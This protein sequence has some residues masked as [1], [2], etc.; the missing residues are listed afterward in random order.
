MCQA[1]C[2]PASYNRVLT[3]AAAV[4]SMSPSSRPE[5]LVFEDPTG[6][7]LPLQVAHF[8]AEVRKAMDINGWSS[9]H[10]LIHMHHSCGTYV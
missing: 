9:G 8:T 10:L 7:M 2:V 5:G 1:M 4:A 3:F 6:Y